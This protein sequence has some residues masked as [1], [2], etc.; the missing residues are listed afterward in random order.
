MFHEWTMR[1]PP[2]DIADESSF[3]CLDTFAEA[4]PSMDTD[5]FVATVHALWDDEDVGN[6]FAHGNVIEFNRVRIEAASAAESD[7]VWKLINGLIARSF[8]KR[9]RKTQTSAIMLKTFPFLGVNR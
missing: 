7:T 6:P 2:D 3:P 1:Y 4:S 9:R 5:E 8:P